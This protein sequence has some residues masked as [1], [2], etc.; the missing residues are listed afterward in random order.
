MPVPPTTTAEVI[1]DRYLTSPAGLRSRPFGPLDA[2]DTHAGRAAQ[3]RIVFLAGE[4]S[5]DTVAERV[6]AWC[7]VG[8]AGVIGI[9]DFGVHDGRAFVVLPPSL[10]VPLER[11]KAMR[12]PSAVDA[13]TLALSFGRLV[14]AVSAAGFAVD[15]AEPCDFAVGPGPTPFLDAPLLGT[16]AHDPV[17]VHGDGQTVIAQIFRSAVAEPLLPAGLS[18]WAAAA[19]AAEFGGVAECLDELELAASAA[20]DAAHGS[21]PVGIAGVFDA[22][23]ALA[24][25]V[26]PTA[27]TRKPRMESTWVRGGIALLLLVSTLSTY[28]AN[29]GGGHDNAAAAAHRPATPAQHANS[30]APRRAVAVPVET[31]P[32]A[33]AGEGPQTAQEAPP[34]AHTEEAGRHKPA[35]SHVHAH[36]PAGIGSDN[37][38]VI[39]RIVGRQRIGRGRRR[40]R[41]A[42]GRIQRAP[43]FRR[44]Q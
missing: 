17:R 30:D 43:S 18:D 39:Q 37:L 11:W 2:L 24:P 33:P 9:L 31:Q 6:A 29:F 5:V 14:E 32:A 26:P 10:G 8:T 20:H 28:H 13:A 35:A 3:V 38:A 12:R 36:E 25:S 7:G 34:P 19:A 41:V 22:P 27:A 21:Q 4:W 15:T 44:R 42:L 1:A 16:V 40:W 23:A